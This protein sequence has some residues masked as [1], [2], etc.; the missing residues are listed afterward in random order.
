MANREGGGFGWL[1][2]GVLLGVVGT[3]AFQL[4]AGK[5]DTEEADAP[6]PHALVVAPAPPVVASLA[7]P[8]IKALPRPALSDAPAAPVPVASE[9]AAPDAQNAGQIADDAAAAGMTSRTTN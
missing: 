8:R 7:K 3:L 9:T 4:F 5:S 2:V 6:P 1:V